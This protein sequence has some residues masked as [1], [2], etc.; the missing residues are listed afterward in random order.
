MIVNIYEQHEEIEEFF[1]E[2]YKPIE[3]ICLYI[4]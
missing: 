1:V 2:Y 3:P 4:K